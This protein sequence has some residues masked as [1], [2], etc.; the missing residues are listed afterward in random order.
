[1][2]HCLGLADSMAAASNAPSTG[3]GMKVTV[4]AG[5]LHLVWTPKLDA[6]PVSTNCQTHQ[7]T[8]IPI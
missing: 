7:M 2:A 5:G 4:C 1:M 6:Q 8:I 3:P